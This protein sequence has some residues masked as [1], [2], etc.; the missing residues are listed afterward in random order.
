MLTSI[1][2]LAFPVASQANT[3]G[4]GAQS[5]S[6]T[7]EVVY[8]DPT[9]AT[10]EFNSDGSD[11][12]RIRSIGEANCTICDRA[13]IQAATRKATLMAKAEIAK[14]LKEKITTSE[15]LD[16]MSKTMTEHNGQT[17]TVSRKSIE[18]LAT[19]I[20]NSSDA[21]LKGIIILEQ[22]SSPADQMVRV[23]VGVS[24]KTM[25]VADSLQRNLNTDASATRQ[26][27]VSPSSPTQTPGSETR[28]SKNY[29]NF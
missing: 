25:G 20:H 3:A 26:S 28:R 12:L 1:A 24:R 13:D 9:G 16:S 5:V 7:K 27:T 6:Q 23:T 8:E 18:T 22:K 17:Q 29:N 15:T 10:I 4:K 14:F 21:I 2:F 19:T 11:W